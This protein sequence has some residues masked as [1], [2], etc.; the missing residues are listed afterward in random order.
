MFRYILRKRGQSTLEYALLIGV[1]VAGLIV[2]QTYLKRG[3]QGKLRD[4]ADSIGKQFTPEGTTYNYT[5]NSYTSTSETLKD[6]VTNSVILN[7]VTNRY[8]NET[9]EGVSD[10]TMFE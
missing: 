6:G 5:V 4:S 7:S 10:E 3:Y 8:S 9:V 2:M 1:I